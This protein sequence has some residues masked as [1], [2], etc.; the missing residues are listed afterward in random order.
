MAGLLIIV[1]VFLLCS[2]S[3]GRNPPPAPKT[4]DTV[5]INQ[6]TREAYEMAWRN[7]GQ[8]LKKGHQALSLS[9]ET[10][11]NKGRAD[12]FLSL[13]MA[14]LA[15]FNHADSALFYNEKA[16]QH[17]DDLDDVDG[18]ARACYALSYVFSFRGDLD[19]SRHYCSQSLDY[20]EQS[21]N[22][23]GIINALNGL[24]YLAKQQNN[25]DE[26]LSFV[27][28]AVE[29]ARSVDDSTALPDVLNSMG[30]LYKE[31]GLF[32][33]AID[34]YFE[35]LH[36]WEETNDSTGLSIAYGSIGLM[37]FYQKDY[38]KA[39]EFTLK[40]LPIVRAKKELWEVSKTYNNLAN[41]YSAM[42]VGDSALHYNRKNLALNQKMNYKSGMV[43]AFHNLASAMLLKAEIDSA[44]SYGS[45]A[46]ELARQI[47][48]PLLANAL[49]TRARVDS[50]GH[51]FSG[52][53]KDALEAYRLARGY[54][55]PLLI[56]E[57]SELLSNLYSRTGRKD[58][59]YDYLREYQQITD[60]ITTDD[61][62]REITRLDLQYDYD[63][64][65]EAADFERKQERLLNESRM[66][67]QRLI[68]NGLLILIFLL[69]LISLL[70]I[71]HS[72]FRARYARIDLEQRLLRAQMNPHFIFNALCAV[73]EFIL[74]GKSREA[75]TFLTKIARLMRNI[76]EHTRQEYVPLDQEIET[77]KL[78]LD[79][80]QMRFS[81]AFEY[82]FSVD[83]AIDPENLSVPP[84]L[85]QP[86]VENSI[87]HGLLPRKEAGHL[88]ISYK[89]ANGLLRLEIT[90][91]GVGRQQAGEVR[92]KRKKKSISTAL[93]RRR[94]EFFRKE[95]KNGNISYDIIDLQDGGKATGTKVVMLLPYKKM[96]S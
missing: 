22:N 60:S 32:K 44:R 72:R 92:R 12:A 63:K 77:L 88:S 18:K 84:M 3:E 24:S 53:L 74:A 66:A 7:P 2:P 23:R 76:L 70:Y 36:L 87:E 26:A 91:D 96:F 95:L 48:D 47:N 94:L 28:E 4:A 68:R 64:K 86:C 38:E 65:Q 52:S 57:A 59:A 78:Y 19:K 9:E 10:G 1:S 33:S 20:F 16:F 79:L 73:Q 43:M 90:D 34:T 13:G 25:L 29:T 42:N 75:N 81:E 35:A 30:N 37:Y 58:L 41:I 50:A 31:M 55:R 89:L 80:Q 61:F 17:Y 85:A 49:I 21:G 6:L 67:R 45:R 46:V 40:K 54:N 71:R 15:M 82:H 51:N 56:A 69:V 27:R 83:E 8:S 62:H 39:L 5:V 14:H 11:Y 93:T